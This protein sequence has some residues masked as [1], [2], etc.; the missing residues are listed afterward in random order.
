MFGHLQNAAIHGHAVV[1]GRNDEIGPPHQALLVDLV[2]MNERASG[3]LATANAFGGVRPG[4]GAHV[5]GENLGIVE[6]LLKPLDAVQH[7]DQSRMV[8]ME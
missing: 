4:D 1:T 7:L 6:Q 2:V 5:L 8:V 3:R